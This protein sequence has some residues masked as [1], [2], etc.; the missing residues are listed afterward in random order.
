M[1]QR[2]CSCVF[3]IAATEPP[4]EVPNDQ[5]EPTLLGNKQ[6]QR[7]ALQPQR[8]KKKIRAGDY[9]QVMTH[10]P[11]LASYEAGDRGEVVCV[12]DDT[13]CKVWFEGYHHPILVASW[14]LGVLPRSLNPNC[15]GDISFTLPGKR[16]RS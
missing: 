10:A 9:V 8:E 6:G 11:S 3:K 1:L 7:G 16:R 2:F 13:R 5:Q 15:K 12:V 4:S 14:S